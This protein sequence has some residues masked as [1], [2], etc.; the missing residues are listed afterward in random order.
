MQRL[1]LLLLQH[2]DNSRKCLAEPYRDEADRHKPAV[3]HAKS[4]V[5]YAIGSLYLCRSMICLP[6]T[7]YPRHVAPDA[8]LRA[9]PRPLWRWLLRQRRPKRC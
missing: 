9:S 3:R 5:A 7:P 8:G 4:H 1:D 6:A 2:C